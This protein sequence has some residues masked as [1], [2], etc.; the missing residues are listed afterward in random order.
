MRHLFTL[1][2]CVALFACFL[3]PTLAYAETSI[4]IVDVEKVLNDADAAKALNK[5]RADAREKFLATLSKQEQSLREEGK[6]LFEKKKELSEEE[7]VKQQKAYE[8]KVLEVRKATQKQKRA[9]DEA[10]A[11]ALEK[12]KDHLETAVQKIA[13]EESYNLVLSNRDVIM[14]EKSLDITAATIKAMNDEK[15][16][17][18]FDVKK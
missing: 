10:S 18:P 11:I 9:F 12:L 6:T 7:F 3:A 5:K 16:K 1:S 17:I 2:V 14:G 4:A 8:S 15:I 13:A